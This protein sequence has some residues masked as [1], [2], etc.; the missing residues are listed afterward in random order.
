MSDTIKDYV[1]EHLQ[2]H[3]KVELETEYGTYYARTPRFKCADGYEVSIQCGH[4]LYCT[5]R[6]NNACP[7]S[8]VELGYPNEHDGML[9]EWCEAPST[10][11]DTVYAY[12][13]VSVVNALIEK[14]G[15]PAREP[16]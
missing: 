5:P 11:T 3:M 14:H 6:E 7:Y 13:P 12:V 2:K 10:P 4:G 16:K 8:A 15:G 9:D 1:N